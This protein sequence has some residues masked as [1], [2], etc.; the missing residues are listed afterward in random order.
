MEAGTRL[1]LVQTE[2]SL[3]MCE[4][5][6]SAMHAELVTLAEKDLYIC[7][8]HRSVTQELEKAKKELRQFRKE[9]SVLVSEVKQANNK[10][11][12][13][14][15]LEI[16]RKIEASEDKQRQWMEAT[17]PTLISGRAAVGKQWNEYDKYDDEL[18]S[19]SDTN[20]TLSQA[21]ATSKAVQHRLEVKLDLALERM[22]AANTQVEAL[23]RNL[24]DVLSANH[25]A[26]PAVDEEG[27]GMDR[28][29]GRGMARLWELYAPTGVITSTV[30]GS[31]HLGEPNPTFQNLILEVDALRGNVKQAEDFAAVCEAEKI[32]VAAWL[33]EARRDAAGAQEQL[34]RRTNA[35]RAELERR[36]GKEI[37]FL[38]QQSSEQHSTQVRALGRLRSELVK[39]E[40]ELKEARLRLQLFG[41]TGG[42]VAEGKINAGE[43]SFHPPLVQ[44]NALQQERDFLLQ[45][46]DR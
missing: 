15:G 30:S 22:D 18:N 5:R 45:R 27:D 2:K 11:R 1:A 21:L 33:D 28:G 9:K 14:A 13:Q 19:A 6:T 35:V 32:R 37:A 34:G 42:D 16:D 43:V 39:K 24:H 36:H 8:E 46:N 40:E 31:S 23:Q 41:D 3:A 44:A 7:A 26:S 25:D 10:A 12:L 29:D 17:L 4:T 38:Q 20:A